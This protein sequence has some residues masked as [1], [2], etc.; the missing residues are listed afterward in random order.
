MLPRSKTEGSIGRGEV[1]VLAPKQSIEL[2]WPV[3]EPA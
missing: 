1:R 2:D 3:N